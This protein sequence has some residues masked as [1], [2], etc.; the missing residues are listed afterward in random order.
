MKHF[1]LMDMFPAFCSPEELDYRQI[2]LLELCAQIGVPFPAERNKSYG[3]WWHSLHEIGH[4]AVKPDWY[5]QYAEYLIDDLGTTWGSLEIP[6][7]SVPGVNRDIVLPKVGRYVGG[8]DVIPEIGLYI[9]PTP[10]EHE[11]RVWS[12]QF[13][14]KMGWNHPFDDNPQCFASGNHF[15]HKPASARVWATPQT[16]SPLIRKKMDRWGLDVEKGKF[17]AVDGFSPPHPTPV[18][19]QEMVSNMDAIYEYFGVESLT[20]EERAYW[21]SF[22]ARR[23]SDSDLSERSKRRLHK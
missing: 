23:W 4:W 11:T 22:L 5:I 17:R 19:H 15:F 2:T 3:N 1:T 16:N 6:A 20:A 7:G 18:C 12:L 21:L 13:I 8:N 10:G 9:D 14:E